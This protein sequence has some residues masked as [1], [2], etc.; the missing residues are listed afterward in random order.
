ME[1]SCYPNNKFYVCQIPLAENWR[2][3]TWEKYEIKN[4]ATEII[5]TKT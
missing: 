2:N 1:L 3:N 5:V 4:M